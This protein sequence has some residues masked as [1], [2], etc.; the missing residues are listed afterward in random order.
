MKKIFHWMTLG[1][2]LALLAGLIDY[3]FHSYYWP[4]LDTLRLFQGEQFFDFFSVLTLYI[5]V[6]FVVFLLSKL[7]KRLPKWIY[8]VMGLVVLGLVVAGL[9]FEPAEPQ[10]HSFHTQAIKHYLFPMLGF[11]MLWS[12]LQKKKTRAQFMNVLLGSFSVLGFLAMFEYLFKVLP[13]ENVDFLG[14]LAWPYIDPFT[15]GKVESANNLSFLFGPVLLLSITEYY[16]RRKWPLLIPIVPAL[17]VILLSQSYTGLLVLCAL[18]A[19]LI[20]L[21]AHPKKRWKAMGMLL[22][23]GVVGLITQ[24]DNPKFQILTGQAD[25][26]LP[27]SIERRVQIYSFTWEKMKEDPF[28]GIGP[29]NYQSTFRAEQ[30]RFLTEAIP[31][32]EMPPLPHNLTLLW[33]SDLGLAGLIAILA[34]YAHTGWQIIK[35]PLARPEVFAFAYLLGHGLADTPYG[36]EEFSVAF[37]VT[38]C[39]SCVHE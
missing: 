20:F 32:K 11:V 14:R 12:G 25:Y 17:S 8:A 39:L 26:T 30:E 16:Q 27:N 37:W 2:P 5:A 6:M 24:L 7:W 23:L 1:F 38:L 31:E 9:S 13:G 34:L 15:A 33:W 10:I 22:A 35:K 36:L 4:Q 3:R 19:L 28:T 18:I 21:I 29:G